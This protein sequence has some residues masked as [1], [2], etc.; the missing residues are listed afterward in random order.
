[1]PNVESAGVCSPSTRRTSPQRRGTMA[2]SPRATPAISGAGRARSTRHTDAPAL[3]P[4]PGGL[5]APPMAVTD[6]FL[7]YVLE[8][9]A[10]LGHVVQRRMFGGAGLYH[11]ERFFGLIARDTLYFK[12][13]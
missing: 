8:Q 5:Y 7:Q 3:S 1:M 4:T 12:V 2:S 13:D 10:G 6:D 11:D 9:L